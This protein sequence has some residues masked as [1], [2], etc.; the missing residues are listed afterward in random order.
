[1]CLIRLRQAH[2]EP[3]IEYVVR[4]E[5][6]PVNKTSVR[7]KTTARGGYLLDKATGVAINPARRM[8]EADRRT[9]GIRRNGQPRRA[10]SPQASTPDS[11]KSA[12]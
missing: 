7:V 4:R 10:Q 8:S 3:R 11:R 5:L 12:A 1:M 2:L 6:I 9:R